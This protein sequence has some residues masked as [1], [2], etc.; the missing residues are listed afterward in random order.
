MLLPPLPVTALGP[1]VKDELKL[2]EGSGELGCNSPMGI[3]W[4]PIVMFILPF[5]KDPTCARCSPAGPA[6]HL[7]IA[8]QMPAVNHSVS[9][10]RVRDWLISNGKTPKEQALKSRLRDLA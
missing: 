5:S 6:A 9:V 1:K 7:E 3:K 2:K 8:A 10:Q 4:M